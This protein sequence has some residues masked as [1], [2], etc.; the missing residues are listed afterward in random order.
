M[1]DSIASAGP[2]PRSEISAN[3]GTASISGTRIDEPAMSITP[4]CG[5][6]RVPL[7]S[8]TVFT[9]PSITE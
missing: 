6:V 9:L 4:P 3:T 5:G 8:T 7:V 1:T 2:R